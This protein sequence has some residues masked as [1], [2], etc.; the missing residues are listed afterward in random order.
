MHTPPAGSFRTHGGTDWRNKMSITTRHWNGTPL[1]QR[2]SCNVLAVLSICFSFTVYAQW[3]GPH[4]I[5]SEAAAL[6]QAQEGV[7]ERYNIPLGAGGL[8]FSGHLQGVYVDNVYLSHSDRR[9]DFIL[10]P[11]LRAGL[12]MPVG[13]LNTLDLNLGLSYY[14]YFEN[15]ELN[16]EEVIVTPQTDLQFNIYS[17]DVRITLRDTFSY[18]VS[19]FYEIGGD[20]YNVYDTGLFKRFRNRARV[21]A[22]WDLRHL[23]VDGGYTHED[24]FSNG[25]EY[26]FID[27]SSELFNASVLGSVEPR[28]SVGIETA[29]G[30]HNYKNFDSNDHLRFSIGPTIR[31]QLSQFLTARAGAGYMRLEFDDSDRIGLSGRDLPYA[32]LDVEHELT[33]FIRQNLQFAIDQRPGVNAANLEGTHIRYGLTWEAT[34]EVRVNPYAS[35]TWY[36]ESFGSGQNSSLYYEDFDYVGA[37]LAIQWAFAPNWTGDLGYEYRTKDSD[38]AGRGYHYNRVTARVSYNF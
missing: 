8:D 29:F 33:Q 28:L 11:E 12:F 21:E 34:P 27:R 23:R 35:Y 36:E 26:D 25:S 19:P 15:T 7:P 3:P 5:A 13:R 1:L 32:Y 20:F 31:A 18:L 2:Y 38:E 22:T 17:G 10:I 37:G 24:F 16:T 30:I 6:A 14:H 9:E 4:S